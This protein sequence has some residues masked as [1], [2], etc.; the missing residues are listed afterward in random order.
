MTGSPDDTG[1]RLPQ[2]SSGRS[3]APARRRPSDAWADL[4]PSFTGDDPLFAG[5]RGTRHS[6]PGKRRRRFLGYLLVAIFAFILG[7]GA[8]YAR[9]YFASGE[10][11]GTVTV[12]V[13]TG[14]TLSSIARE[15]EAQGRGQARARVRDPRRVGRLRHEIH[16]RHLHLPP[17]R[18]LRDA[19]R[20]ARAR[21]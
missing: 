7:L 10:L 20:P 15:L 21:A 17:Q 6:R 2:P 16:A 13:P 8:G 5:R 3:A 18:A 19:R 12:V 1:T 4:E 9:G 14:A 11:G